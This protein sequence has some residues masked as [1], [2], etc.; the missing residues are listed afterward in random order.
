MLKEVNKGEEVMFFTR[1]KPSE[2]KVTAEVVTITPDIAKY[3]LNNNEGNRVV[4]KSHV[5]SLAASILRGEWKLS[6]QGII[7]HK[8]TGRLLDGQHRLLAIIQADKPVDMFVVKTEDSEVYKVLDQGAKRSTGDIFNVNSNIAGTVNY[9]CRLMMNRY[10]SLSP[11]QVE[12]VL[13][14]TLGYLAE[15]LYEF[16]PISRKGFS[17]SP[18][19]AAAVTS[20]ML[21]NDKRRV[22][23][24]YKNLV[25]A[26]VDL[27]PPVGNGFIAQVLSGNI[28]FSSANGGRV[29]YARAFYTY[30]KDNSGRIRIRMSEASANKMA[31]E[32]A[33]KLKRIL[34]KDGSIDEDWGKRLD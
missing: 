7:L 19:K 3:L 34:V 18:M 16:C 20:V 11:Q 26:N 27:L 5:A 15:E 22:F 29:L 1:N 10:S 33:E 30:D 4:R 6:P 24:I 9:C 25:N 23:N 2:G 31:T 32:H 8:S 17:S 21:G 12:P 28:D 14:S 13:H